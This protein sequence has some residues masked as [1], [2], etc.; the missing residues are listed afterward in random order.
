MLIKESEGSTV[1]LSFDFGSC[2]LW[3]SFPFNTG[4]LTKLQRKS[5]ESDVRIPFFLSCRFSVFLSQC[6]PANKNLWKN[7]GRKKKLKKWHVTKD[8][9]HQIWKSSHVWTDSTNFSQCLYSRLRLRFVMAL[10]V[11]QTLPSTAAPTGFPRTFP[12]PSCEGHGFG[13]WKQGWGIKGPQFSYQLP[14]QLLP[15]LV[16]SPKKNPTN[17]S[18]T[19]RTIIFEENSSTPTMTFPG[20]YV[21][22]Q[23]G[24]FK[25][26]QYR[27]IN[28]L[29][30]TYIHIH[31]L[32]KEKTPKIFLPKNLQ[33]K[34]S[35]KTTHQKKLLYQGRCPKKSS[36]RGP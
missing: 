3:T 27:G 16:Y 23:G 10:W 12:G 22:F 17:S 9:L 2:C 36:H 14:P 34:G 5:V 29:Q 30:C 8:L 4:T 33:R 20:G 11:I 7:K 26:Q 32:K 21:S 35:P 6:Q 13:P 31:F 19:Q 25:W 15:Y 28:R 1:V 18:P 24:C